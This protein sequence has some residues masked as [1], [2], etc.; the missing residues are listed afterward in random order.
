M[1]YRLLF[2]VFFILL[3]AHLTA[4][5]HTNKPVSIIFDS[6]IGPDYDDTGAIT[7]LHAMADNGEAK[8]LATVASNQYEGIAS[9]LNIF[10]THFNRPGIP[11]GVPKGK[12]V[13]M[14]D[15]QHWTDTIRM[16]YPHKI[17]FNNEVP[18][19][20]EVYRKVL[21]AQPDHSVTIVTVGFLTNL[22]NLLKT[23][24]DSYSPLSGKALIKKK[25]KLLVSMAGIYPSGKEFNIIEDV[26]SSKEALENW[27]TPVIFSGFEI[28]VKIK[29]GLPMV[30]NN[31]IHNSPAK[32]V[33][34][35]CLP[36]SPQ[37]ADGR[38]SWDETAVLVAVR[39]YQPYYT[40]HQGKIKVADDGIDSWDEN[41]KGQ[42]YLVEKESPK[43]MEDII[44]HLMMQHPKH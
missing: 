41:G 17:K 18:D 2:S 36:M 35:I 43:N 7:I 27:P 21:A 40:L 15:T 25:I 8:I 30:N 33:F 39:G 32:D 24:S 31:E 44:N 22:A 11:I 19:A 1:F 28:G 20:V 34:K 5:Q 26:T 6:D 4:Q 14:K 12:A 38:M 23:T 29:T 42:F 37:D 13:N 10:N 3:T 16:N 9:V